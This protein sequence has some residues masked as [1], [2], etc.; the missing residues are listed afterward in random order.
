[1]KL[2]TKQLKQIINEELRSLLGESEELQK[3]AQMISG[4]DIANIKQGLNQIILTGMTDML[5]IKLV[6]VINDPYV[7]YELKVLKGWI[8][9]ILLA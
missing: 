1:M 9:R 8:E 6:D 5:G 7:N 2:T 3:M 4:K